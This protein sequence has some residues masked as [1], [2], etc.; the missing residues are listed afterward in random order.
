MTHELHVSISPFIA[1]SGE[2]L[3]PGIGP[4]SMDLTAVTDIGD[5]AVVL[6]YA[7]GR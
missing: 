7:P 1:G 6:A 4:T 2:S 5:G 3:L